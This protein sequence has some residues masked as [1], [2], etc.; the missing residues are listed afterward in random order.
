MRSKY[1]PRSMHLAL[2]LVALTLS[3][4]G[5]N[6]AHAQNQPAVTMTLQAGFDGYYEIGFW[7][8]LRV[9]LEN[10][11]PPVE[12]R[13]EVHAPRL[14]S[15]EAVYAYPLSLPTASRKEATF[16]V[17]PED[18]F[19]PLEATFVSS[20]GIVVARASLR[21]KA[22]GDTDRLFGVLSETSSAFNL[23]AEIDPADGAANVAQLKTGD[24]PDHVQAFEALDAIVISNVDAGLL[25]ADQIAALKDWVAGGGR[26]IV[27]G[28]PNWQKTTTALRD[29]LPFTPNATQ[30][31]ADL[32][33]L[34][35]FAGSTI[36]LPGSAVVTTGSPAQ[37]SEI[38]AAQSGLP[39]IAR[40]RS[41]LGEVYF[42]SFDPTLAPFKSW[43]GAIEVYRRLLG[44]PI[45]RPGWG[46]GIQDWYSASL[47]AST[48][49]D[50]SLPTSSLICGFLGLYIVAIG[51]LNYLIVRLTKRRD[52]AWV[53]VPVLVIVFSLTAFGIGSQLRGSQPVLSRLAVVQVWPEENRAR[54][55]GVAGLFSPYRA[56]YQLTIDHN[57]L[58]HP[59]PIAYFLA[60]NEPAR[61]IVDQTDRILVPDLQMDVAG[62]ALFSAEGRVEAPP[63]DYELSLDAD[64]QD[65]SI[66]GQ[67]TYRG[68]F[69]LRDAMLLGPGEALS[70]GTLEPGESIPI[71]LSLAKS[72][73]ANT[74]PQTLSYNPGGNSTVED[75][76]GRAYYMNNTSETR[77]RQ[78][79]LQM[80]LNQSERGGGIYLVGWSDRSPLAASIDGATF[81][82]LDTTLYI[83]RLKPSLHVQQ[84]QVT[85]PPGMFTWQLITSRSEGYA[86]YDA[87]VY[88]GSYTLLFKLAQPIAYS[89]VEALTLHLKS[90]QAIGPTQL[91]FSVWDFEAQAWHNLPATN[92][93]D[94]DIPDPARFVG[95]GGEIRLQIDGSNNSSGVQIEASDFTLVVRN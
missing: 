67:A 81:D 36:E 72:Q 74:A 70:L 8:P 52:L 85:I 28:G 3:L 6:A 89:S 64:R 18:S 82:T 87:Y 39:L 26:L 78:S 61:T 95:S 76:L 49:T 1:H 22:N 83:F 50:L 10:D 27:T 93:G 47:A 58:A 90:Y 7:L 71:Q 32:G 45:E 30:T 21:L 65:A 20:D 33:A 46:Y 60:S 68:E 9:T 4:N 14:N 92:W 38:L 91:A 79:L 24:L 75:I 2:L 35:D 41:G 37:D 23:L 44:A 66:S 62:F 12:G 42:L 17:F 51:P 77:R 55:T 53:N 5:L 88:Q 63:I 69:T 80:T 54:A 34:R 43:D 25:T 48:L 94:I 15:G 73:L 16:Y 31:L 13:V 86:P 57:L 56:A 84:G 29:L 19:N 59:M 11:G 40:Q